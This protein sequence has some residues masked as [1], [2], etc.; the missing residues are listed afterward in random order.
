MAFSPYSSSSTS[1][2]GWLLLDLDVWKEENAV[3]WLNRLQVVL[4]LLPTELLLV[5]MIKVRYMA[6]KLRNKAILQKEKIILLHTILFT[7]Y[8]TM[9]ASNII[10]YDVTRSTDNFQRNCRASITLISMTFF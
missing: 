10:A 4:T 9:N 6:S 1:Y 3:Y 2:L 5:A 8:F 7:L